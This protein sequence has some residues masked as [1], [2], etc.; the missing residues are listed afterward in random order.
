MDMLKIECNK[1]IYIQQLQINWERGG[2][3]G[4]LTNLGV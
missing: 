3:G 1:C 4:S 2:G